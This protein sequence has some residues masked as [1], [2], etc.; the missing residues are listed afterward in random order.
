MMLSASSSCAI[1]PYRNQ[2]QGGHDGQ[3]RQISKTCDVMTEK[4]DVYGRHGC[5]DEVTQ[6]LINGLV[7]LEGLFELQV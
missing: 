2:R 3:C 7:R 6:G 1:L 4:V 5:K